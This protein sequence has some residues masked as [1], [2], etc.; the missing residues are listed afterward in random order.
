MVDPPPLR[1]L[2]VGLRDGYSYGGRAVRPR[3]CGIA[4][5]VRSLNCAGPARRPQNWPAKLWRGALC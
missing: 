3:A 2:C 4:L 5:G 1:E